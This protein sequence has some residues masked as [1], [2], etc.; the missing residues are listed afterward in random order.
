[1]TAL[2]CLYCE[3]TLG[4]RTGSGAVQLHHVTGRPGARLAYLD[5]ALTVPL[6]QFHHSFDHRLWGEA[7][8]A[9]LA[10][11]TRARIARLAFFARRLGCREEPVALLPGTWAEVGRALERAGS[12]DPLRHSTN[13]ET[14]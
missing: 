3:A 9:S 6:C 1:M 5:P 2:G 10:D 13:E 12:H 14:P 8:I 7:G 11:P 4:A